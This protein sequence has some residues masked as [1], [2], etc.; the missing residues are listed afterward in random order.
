MLQLNMNKFKLKIKINSKWIKELNVRLYII[1]FL[2]ENI[3]RTY[4]DI[5]HSNTFL[6]LSP[7]VKEMKVKIN[8]WSLID[9]LMDGRRYLQMTKLIRS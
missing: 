2:E 1:K 5:N 4:F 7:K 3:Y 9:T 8:K 6:D